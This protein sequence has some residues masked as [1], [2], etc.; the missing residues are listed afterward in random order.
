MELVYTLQAEVRAIA[1]YA[2]VQLTRD[3]RGLPIS[4]FSDSR[5]VLMAVN[6]TNIYSKE[7]LHC[8]DILTVLARDNAVF[9]LRPHDGFSWDKVQIA[10]NL[11]IYRSKCCDFKVFIHTYHFH[12]KTLKIPKNVKNYGKKISFW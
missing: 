6:C 4:I 9:F 2:A 1:E 8:I 11:Y 12:A 5:A 10:P 3:N 7:V